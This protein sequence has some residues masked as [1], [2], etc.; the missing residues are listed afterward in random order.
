MIKTGQIVLKGVIGYTIIKL[1][2]MVF[3][4]VS[5]VD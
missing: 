1:G 4:G 2:Q 3:K 5:R